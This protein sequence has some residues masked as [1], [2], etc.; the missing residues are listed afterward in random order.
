MKLAATEVEAGNIFILGEYKQKRGGGKAMAKIAF[1]KDLC[2]GCKTCEHACAVAHSKAKDFLG[3]IK[4][5]AKSRINIK[6]LADKGTIKAV[7]C[8]QCGKAKCIEAC[9]ADALTKNERG[10]VICDHEK[11]VGCTLCEEFCPFDAIV[12]DAD[13]D[14]AI[15]CDLCHGVC[16]EPACVVA[17]PTKALSVKE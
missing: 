3:A 9:P 13:L 15:K 8:A 17:C 4:E 12:V 6:Y 11:C 2:T 7:Q 10:V 1:K 14:K 5:G 16:D